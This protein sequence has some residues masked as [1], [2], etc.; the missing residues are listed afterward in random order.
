[1]AFLETHNSLFRESLG[2]AGFVNMSCVYMGARRRAGEALVSSP[3]QGLRLMSDQQNI[4]GPRI[5]TLIQLPA[6]VEQ[7]FF[8]P[9][10]PVS[11]RKRSC[12]EKKKE[13][14]SAKQQ[15]HSLKRMECV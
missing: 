4:S 5:L 10:F 14:T 7:S 1:M 9:A 15:F 8:M 3:N 12:E 6:W 11:E 2:L 13:P